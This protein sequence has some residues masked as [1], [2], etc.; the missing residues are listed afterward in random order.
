MEI[1]FVGA[2]REVTGSCHLLHVNGYT[3]ALDCGMFQGKRQDSAEKNRK[4]PLAIKDLDAVILSHA[5]IDHSGRLPYLIAE[6]YGNTIWATAATRD[7]CAIMLADSAHIQEKDAEFLAKRKKE[8]IEPLYGMR[9][10]VRTMDL[11]IGVPYNK[12]FDVVPGVRASYVDAGHILGSASVL[13]DCTEDG[14]TKRLVF[15]GDIGRGGLAIVRDPVPPEGADALIMESTYGN[16]DHESVEGARAQLAQVVRETAGRGG[17][18]L[19]PAFAVAR[20]Q[21][22]IYALHGLVREGAIPAIPIYVDSP[23]AIDATTVFE[24]HPESFDRS[25]EMVRKVD[26]LFRFDL[27]HYTRDVEESK[28]ISRSHGPMIVIAASGMMEN[29]RILHHLAQGAGDPRNTIL[30]VGFQAEH[31]LGR[32]VVERQPVLQIFGEDVALNARVEVIDG[33][34]AHADRTELAT[35]LGRVK[36]KSPKL[37]PIWLVHGEAPVQDEFK[38][39][40]A[41][42]GYSVECPEPHTRR[43]F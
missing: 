4:L 25:E 14:K 35:W 36:E 16:R 20:T 23:L 31:T 28:A 9:H 29:G 30:V 18:I 2:A 21:E 32:R 40:L 13:V 39:A 42:K 27:L 11:M 1:T 37:G 5:H 7:L 43:A 22:I 41:A 17:R 19:I 26:E 24:M 6:G 3:V 34:S 10:A 12:P 8:F 38:A 15:S 33:Y